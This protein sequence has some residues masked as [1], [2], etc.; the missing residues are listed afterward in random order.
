MLDPSPFV[1]SARELRAGVD[2]EDPRVVEL[3]DEL[4]AHSATFRRLWARHDVRVSAPASF[5]LDQPLVGPL[6]LKPERF[7]IIGTESQVLIVQHT[8]PGSPSERAL[9]LLIEGRASHPRDL[10]THP[11]RSS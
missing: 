9:Q 11:Q 3:V 2:E 6:V 4:S 7:A 5:G 8:E 10:P 1:E